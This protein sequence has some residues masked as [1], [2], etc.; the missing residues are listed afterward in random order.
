MLMRVII[1]RSVFY[2]APLSK[3]IKADML[4]ELVVIKHYKGR[5]MVMKKMNTNNKGFS[6]VEL[7]IV[8]AI[9]GLL[10]AIGVPQY[11]KF[12]ARARQSEAKAALGALYS[13][14]QAF[15]QEWNCYSSDLRNVG[16]GVTGV[17]LRYVTGFSTA[18][19]VNGFGC[20][21]G[22]PA[23][24]GANFG[25]SDGADAGA[26]A[27]VATATVTMN[28]ARTAISPGTQWALS[29]AQAGFART[30][31]TANAALSAAASTFTGVSA[32][33][34]KN[35]INI[36]AAADADAWSI[37]NLKTISNAQPRL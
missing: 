28:P 22:V 34:P 12:Q 2:D 15:F 16:F 31:V 8:V 3:Q 14:E 21:A 33:D 18:A 20:N 35:T 30:Y 5:D 23:V 25:L 17:N 4:F 27:V 19:T 24:N 13:A 32:G 26:G 1:N 10:A 36:T 7:M 9:I 11:A 29:N 37:N 6:L